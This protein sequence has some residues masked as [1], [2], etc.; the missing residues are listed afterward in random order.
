MNWKQTLCS[1]VCR[2]RCS[3]VAEPDMFGAEIQARHAPN[4]E[5]NVAGLRR[6]QIN[7]ASLQHCSCCFRANVRA[8]HGHVTQ[9]AVLA[10][11]QS[12]VRHT[13]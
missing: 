11:D 7:G 2:T 4:R 13:Q 10:E 3:F 8:F 1:V 9:R 6:K 12:G 5:N